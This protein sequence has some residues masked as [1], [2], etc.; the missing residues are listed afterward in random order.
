[1]AEYLFP[2]GALKYALS[3]DFGTKVQKSLAKIMEFHS[4]HNGNVAI[5]FSGGLDSTVLL[6]LARNTFPNMRAVFLDTG[7]ENKEVVEHVRSLDNIDVITPR[8]CELNQ[9]KTKCTNCAFGCFGVVIKMHGVC[10]PD[11]NTA[12]HYG[13]YIKGGYSSNKQYLDGKLTDLLAETKNRDLPMDISD[14]CCYYLKKRPLDKWHKDNGMFPIIGTRANESLNRTI[15]WMK[16][17]CNNF[18]KRSRSTPLA[19]WS[20]NDV[21]LYLKRFDV[22]Y[23]SIYGEI[24]EDKKGKLRNTGVERTGCAV[25]L[26]QCGKEIDGITK[27][28]RLKQSEPELWNYGVNTCG[29]GAFMDCFGIR[30]GKEIISEHRH[31]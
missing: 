12:K 15:A 28:E 18:G 2:K 4:H 30:Y 5:N 26:V 20:K 29:L 17:G 6:H 25:C 13:S 7:I 1:M 31:N 21:L 23:P 16:A 9:K 8:Y 10:Y 22:P 19:F 3:W 24:T 27:F 14:R 11:K